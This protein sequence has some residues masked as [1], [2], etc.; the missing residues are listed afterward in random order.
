MYLFNLQVVSHKF[1]TNA[2]KLPIYNILQWR[3][4]QVK[5]QWHQLT[6]VRRQELAFH[7]LTETLPTFPP[8]YK[9]IVGTEKYDPKYVIIN[10]VLIRLGI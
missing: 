9:F 2:K 6:Q 3:K 4:K 1:T 8:T 5:Q 10:V 7:E